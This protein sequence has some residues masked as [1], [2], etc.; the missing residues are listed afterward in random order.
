MSFSRQFILAL[1]AYYNIISK[2]F[3]L[4]YFSFSNLMNSNKLKFIAVI[5]QDNISNFRLIN[6]NITT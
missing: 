4:A 3:K 1:F 2:Y 5:C 6:K